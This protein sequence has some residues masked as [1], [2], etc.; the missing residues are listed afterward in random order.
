M[1]SRKSIRTPGTI[2][3]NTESDWLFA[4]N[5]Y[6]VPKINQWYLDRDGDVQQCQGLTDTN[7]ILLKVIHE[8]T[9]AV[10]HRY[11]E[12]IAPGEEKKTKKAGKRVITLNGKAV[13]C[14]AN[15]RR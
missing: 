7:Y 13:L 14:G 10:T 2:I 8:I 1:N 4:P 5:G 15:N 3:R 6:G 11:E 9:L 12:E